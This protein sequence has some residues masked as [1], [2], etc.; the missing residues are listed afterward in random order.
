MIDVL[1]AIAVVAVLVQI[2]AHNWRQKPV[3]TMPTSSL[4]YPRALADGSIR[5]H[6][7]Y[8]YTN[9]AYANAFV[10][11]FKDHTSLTHKEIRCLACLCT[12]TKTV[13]EHYQPPPMS[14]PDIID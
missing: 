7:T 12:Y 4:R 14:V 11:A 8:A 3:G 1:E 10:I 5:L 13:E 9:Y 6:H 2:K